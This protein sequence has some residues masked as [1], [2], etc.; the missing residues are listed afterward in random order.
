MSTDFDTHTDSSSELKWSDNADATNFLEYEGDLDTTSSTKTDGDTEEEYSAG[1]K[2][3][4]D[5]GISSDD[6]DME[7]VDPDPVVKAKARRRQ[8][9]AVVQEDEEDMMLVD[10]DP[11]VKTK[12]KKKAEEDSHNPVVKSKSK[13]R[14]KKTSVVQE[15]EEVM[16]AVDECQVKKSKMNGKV[17]AT[18]MI[19]E[20]VEDALVNLESDSEYQYNWDLCTDY[21]VEGTLA[22][23]TS[24]VEADEESITGAALDLDTAAAEDDMDDSLFGNLVNEGSNGV[25]NTQLQSPP[26]HPIKDPP[27]A[28]IWLTPRTPKAG[29]H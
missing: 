26:S 22:D 5:R 11:V 7:Q 19:E 9:M 18:G 27:A 12:S 28:D 24:R 2:S 3:M 25:Q 14:Q 17:R 4:V 29:K 8:K 21:N 6:E 1:T 10:E 16:M 13:K 20:D 23:D 15:D